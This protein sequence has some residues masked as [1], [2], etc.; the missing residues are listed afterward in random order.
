MSDLRK[1]FLPFLSK[2]GR[3]GFS[4]IFTVGLGAAFLTISILGCEGF[5][6]AFG[7]SPSIAFLISFFNSFASSF[8]ASFSATF[9]STLAFFTINAFGFAF[10]TSPSAINTFNLFICS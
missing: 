7:L 2:A 9:S 1:S 5:S 8:F 4:T 10:V 3:E 6:A